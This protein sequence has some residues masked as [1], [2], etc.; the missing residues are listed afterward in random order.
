MSWTEIS[1]LKHD[2]ANVRQVVCV[3]IRSLQSLEEKLRKWNEH[4]TGLIT[5]HE[6]ENV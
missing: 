3:S 2:I 1:E 6:D 5:E 4:L